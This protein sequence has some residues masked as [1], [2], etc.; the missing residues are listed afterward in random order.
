MKKPLTALAV[1][2]VLGAGA[3]AVA[4]LAFHSSSSATHTVAGDVR[5]IVVRSDSGD[6]DLVPADGRVVVHETSSYV[7]ERPTLD[8]TLDDGVLT[9]ATGCDGIFLP[10][11]T[12]L[13]ITI[14]A[15]VKVTVDAG[16]GDVEARRVALRDPHVKADSGD[17]MLDL[18]GRQAL[19]WAHTDSG[20]V[21]VATAGASAIDAQTGSG[22]V[23]VNAAGSPRR[24]VAHT[25]SGDVEIAVP[26][27]D[28]AVDADTDSG[29]VDVAAAI[30]RNDRA[31]R[32]IDAKTDSGDVSIRAR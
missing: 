17:V 21:D 14:P 13:R 24:V 2:C 27:G 10:C 18:T 15:G 22:D 3:L 4:T 8:E 16:S 12:D 32:S 7:F 31:P 20:S 19:V 1:L 23:N 28:Y 11:S 29:D 6:V 9:L 26:R 25:D 30:S 5:E